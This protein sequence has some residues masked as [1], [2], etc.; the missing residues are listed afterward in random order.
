MLHHLGRASE[1]EEGAFGKRKLEMR[2]E[3]ELD[4]QPPLAQKQST[5][6]RIKR[7]SDY[8]TAMAFDPQ[9]NLLAVGTQQG[10]VNVYEVTTGSCI[11]QMRDH[12]LM[13][14]T[15]T[16]LGDGRLL[17]GCDDGL[18][19]LYDIFCET[20]ADR[21]LSSQ[22]GS[23]SQ[24]TTEEALRYLEFLSASQYSSISN[25]STLRRQVQYVRSWSAHEGFVTSVRVSRDGR[26]AATW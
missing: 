3:V 7:R 23:S 12:T 21:L 8:G 19:T 14:R 17:T 1:N 9:G 10:C 6:D 25:G 24:G 11:A 13:I 2:N 15:V 5:N 18:V 20:H 16:L 22:G 26:L 4:A